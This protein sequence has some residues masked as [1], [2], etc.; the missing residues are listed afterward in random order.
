VNP[1][2]SRKRG[3]GKPRPL[4]SAGLLSCALT[5]HLVAGCTQCEEPSQKTEALESPAAPTTALRPVPPLV[6]LEKP[7]PFRF[8]LNSSSTLPGQSGQAQMSVSGVLWL[9]GQAQKRTPKVSAVFENLEARVNGQPQPEFEKMVAEMTQG[10]IFRFDEGV[11]QELSLPSSV[12]PQVA[13][14][15]RTIGATLQHGGQGTKVGEWTVREHDSTGEYEAGYRWEGDQLVRTK[16]KYDSVLQSGVETA[17]VQQLLPRVKASKTTMRLTAERLSALTLD[18]TIDADLQKGVTMTVTTHIELEREAERAPLAELVATFGRLEASRDLVSF[19]SES[20]ISLRAIG[21]DQSQFD[22]LRI[23]NWTFQE[24]LTQAVD[25]EELGGDDQ[26]EKTEERR[27]VYSAYAALTAYLRSYPETH[28]EAQKAIR[29]AEAPARVVVS[30][31]GDAGT[32]EAQALLIETI[33]NESLPAELRSRAIVRL[34]RTDVPIP[35]TVEALAAQLENERLW[36]Q[37]VLA[38]GIAGRHF[39]DAGRKEDFD[40]S[41]AVIVSQL[42]K[43]GG[44]DPSRL[45]KVLDAV[46]NLGDARLLPKLRPYLESE[47]E[48]VRAGAAFALRHMKDDAVDP[49]LARALAENGTT[50]SRLRI[51][52]AIRV[53]GPRPLLRKA[54]GELLSSEQTEGQVLTRARRLQESWREVAP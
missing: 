47:D 48:D 37:A 6:A 42:E 9:T 25:V 12:Q 13:N 45:S 26:E 28:P 41:S 35:Q 16:K 15:W 52:S 38:L 5:L 23:K 20:P 10:A 18:E 31:L 32:N 44:V 4:A 51:L 1:V 46:S 19:P 8:R 22:H 29:E 7:T 11:L 2:V 53:R 40:R 39:R 43:Q 30:A 33:A 54:I 49:L 21:V 36:G 50:K 14:L 3:P 17:T 24:A 27:R 34:A